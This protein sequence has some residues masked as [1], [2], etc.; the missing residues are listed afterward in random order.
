MN[1]QYATVLTSIKQKMEQ[2]FTLYEEALSENA[3]LKQQ[4]TTISQELYNC[5]TDKSTLETKVDKLQMAGAFQA[6]TE[7]AK[8]AKLKI[9]RLI[10]EIDKCLALLNR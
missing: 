6:S 1:P 2:I 8:E 5:K 9:G 4:L 3:Q 10:R 7:D